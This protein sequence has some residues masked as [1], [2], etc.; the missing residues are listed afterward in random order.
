[1]IFSANLRLSAVD[2]ECKGI[3]STPLVSRP[4]WAQGYVSHKPS[5]SDPILEE[6]KLFYENYV[7]IFIWYSWQRQ[8][9]IFR[10]QGGTAT[11]SFTHILDTPSCYGM[12]VDIPVHL[13]N[14]WIWSAWFVV[15]EADEAPRT[16]VPVKAPVSRAIVSRLISFGTVSDGPSVNCGVLCACFRQYRVLPSESRCFQHLKK[17]F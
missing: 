11:C 12:Q 7:V 14:I 5:P 16:L 8:F 1:M 10:R 3:L 15:F 4:R 2:Q 9:N 6:G 13:V 17:G